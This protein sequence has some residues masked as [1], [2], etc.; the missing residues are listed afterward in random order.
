MNV[1]LLRRNHLHISATHV[2]I[3]RVMITR[4]EIQL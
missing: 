4:L 2:D 3:F 1:M